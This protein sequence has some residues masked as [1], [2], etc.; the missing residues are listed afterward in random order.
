MNDNNI[1]FMCSDIVYDQIE[2]HIIET[3]NNQLKNEYSNICSHT[4]EFLDK[5]F[6]VL[7]Y[8][9]DN[10]KDLYLF[11]KLKD[12]NNEITLYETT[13]TLYNITNNYSKYH[14]LNIYPENELSPYI[15]SVNNACCCNIRFKTLYYLLI[16][17]ISIWQLCVAS[18]SEDTTAFAKNI[19][20]AST[21][22]VVLS[23]FYIICKLQSKNYYIEVINNQEIRL[24]KKLNPI[25]IKDDDIL[26]LANKIKPIKYTPYKDMEYDKIK[27]DKINNKIIIDEESQVI[28]KSKY[29]FYDTSISWPMKVALDMSDKPY[30]NIYNNKTKRKT[31][32]FISGLDVKDFYKYMVVLHNLLFNNGTDVGNI[33]DSINMGFPDENNISFNIMDC[34]I[35]NKNEN[36][37][38]YI[39]LFNQRINEYALH[40]IMIYLKVFDNK[41]ECRS[42][43]KT[44]EN[45][46]YLIIEHGENV[47]NSSHIIEFDGKNITFNQNEQ[48]YYRIFKE[49]IIKERSINDFKIDENNK[50][51]NIILNK[52]SNLELEKFKIDYIKKYNYIFNKI[53]LAYIIGKY[54]NFIKMLLRYSEENKPYL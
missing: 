1:I 14:E 50:Y 9:N 26:K 20:T 30:F 25:D 19:L 31:K 44:K 34:N 46:Y 10:D 38:G 42:I 2:T 52:A 43:S 23:T 49:N 12:A 7:G 47:R 28:K 21:L 11:N 8:Y 27:F 6:K 33:H 40:S 51:V 22:S 45:N 32:S 3:I 37:L 16:A 18:N 15:Y 36:K 48:I 24:D 53:M 4:E 29:F 13:K 54:F 17:I 41:I 35:F 39:Q 5:G